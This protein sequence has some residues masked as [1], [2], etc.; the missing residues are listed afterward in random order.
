[1]NIIQT[2]SCSLFGC[3]GVARSHVACGRQRRCNF[4]WKGVGRV[5]NLPG[6]GKHT[7]ISTFGK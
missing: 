1:M 3:L 4:T 2:T 6:G 5:R 7:S